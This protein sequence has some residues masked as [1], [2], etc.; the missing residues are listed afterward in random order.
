MPMPSLRNAARTTSEHSVYDLIAFP[1]NAI[2]IV[3]SSPS[4]PLGI[5]QQALDPAP[6]ADEPDHLEHQ[7][8]RQ[9]DVKPV[10]DD[11]R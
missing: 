9:H 11:A 1:P 8:E 6:D 7:Q 5:L 2:E 10:H 4:A 3:S